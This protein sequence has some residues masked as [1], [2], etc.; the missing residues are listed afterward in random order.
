MTLRPSYLAAFTLFEVAIS[1]VILTFGV[2]SVMMIM[3]IGLR[4]VQQSRFQLYAA[5]KAEEM[6]EQFS[7]AHFDNATSDTEGPNCWDAASSYRSQT[8]DLD[9]RI[10]SHR[11]GMMPLPL[12]LAKRLDSNDDEIA[13]IIDGGGLV[14]YSQPLASTGLREQ[15]QGD[16]APPNEAQKMI[17]GITGYAQQ[18]AIPIFPMKNWPYFAASPSPPIHFA[19]QLDP[20]LVSPG[21]PC[22]NTGPMAGRDF[23]D[24]YAYPSGGSR[25]YFWESTR[26]LGPGTPTTPGSNNPIPGTDPDMQKVVDWPESGVRYGYVPYSFSAAAPT[27][28]AAI[29]YVQATLWYCKQKGLPT[30]F[31]DSSN[32]V[33]LTASSI[34]PSFIVGTAPADKWKQVQAMRF[35]SHAATCLTRWYSLTDALAPEDLTKGV[36]IPL[37]TLDGIAGPLE[38]LITDNLIHYYHERSVKLIM[39]FA[40]HHPYDWAVPRPIERTIMVDYPLLQYDMFSA[41]L[42][43]TV[44]G[45]AGISASQWRPLSPRPIRNIGL[46][47]IYPVNIDPVTGRHRL[48]G[49]IVPGAASNLFGDLDHYSLAMPFDASER[50]REL[51]FWT[52]DWQSYEDFE[53]LPSAPLDASRYP[54][55]A[56]RQDM[57]GTPENFNTRMS[58]MTFVDPHLFCYR[59]PEK[60]MLWFNNIPMNSPTGTNVSAHQILNGE[61]GGGGNKDQGSGLPNRMTFAG[62]YGADRNFNKII[63]RGLVPRSVR[64]R[65]T[66]IARFN[67]YDSRIPCL[68]R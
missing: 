24:V 66:Q 1:L 41:P 50:C 51:V 56:P 67:F 6:I 61:N 53:T 60:S 52:V 3:P 39:E 63:D 47:S 45:T 48:E 12:E 27:R 54:I 62:Q 31:W 11:Y 40:A 16:A 35:L 49:T 30:S 18:N 64:M 32:D 21:V 68:L 20:W 4:G 26:I 19:H 55:C 34:V 10:A 8:W 5:A 23:Y 14:Y 25:G 2:V 17:I 15:S 43:G 13:R 59:N 36:K 46:S 29:R 33:P 42:S 58:M 37:V 9:A 44:F 7:T 22:P 38:L 28:D 65:A 57:A